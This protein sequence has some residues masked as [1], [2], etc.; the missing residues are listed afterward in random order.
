MHKR[1]L[2]NGSDTLDENKIAIPDL[3]FTTFGQKVTEA[4]RLVGNGR[5][6]GVEVGVKRKKLNLIEVSLFLT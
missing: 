1:L 5:R 6:Q 2:L 4:W 3:H